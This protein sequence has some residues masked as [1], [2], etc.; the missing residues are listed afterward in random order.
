[1][2]EVMGQ[3]LRSEDKVF[4]S[5]AES[6]IEIGK[7]FAVIVAEKQTWIWNCIQIILPAKVVGTTSSEGLSSST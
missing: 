5:S 4:P 6:E 1:M 2:V 7:T 3:S